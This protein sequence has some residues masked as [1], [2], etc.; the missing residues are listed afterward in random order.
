MI[1]M[2]LYLVMFIQANFLTIKPLSALS[3]ANGKLE[4]VNIKPRLSN[5]VGH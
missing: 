5:H 4:K 3:S 1:F 2:S